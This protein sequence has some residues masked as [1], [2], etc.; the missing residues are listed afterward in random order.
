MSDLLLEP[1]DLRPGI[2][3]RLRSRQEAFDSQPLELLLRAH[4]LPRARHLGD[5]SEGILLY[6]QHRNYLSHR[7]T[8]RIEPGED[9]T[10]GGIYAGFTEQQI[11]G[12]LTLGSASG[13]VRCTTHQIRG[14][15]GH[16]SPSHVSWVPRFRPAAGAGARC[17]APGVGLR[18]A[19][20]RATRFVVD[21]RVAIVSSLVGDGG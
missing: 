7:M 8:V 12:A 9:V 11:S 6:L 2:E 10:P 14:D 16:K 5:A 1:G 19:N 18:G 4:P 21:L 15:L 13:S 20:P 17:V 3:K